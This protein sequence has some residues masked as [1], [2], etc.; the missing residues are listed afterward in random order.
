MILTTRR[1]ASYEEAGELAKLAAARAAKPVAFGAYNNLDG[2]ERQ[3]AQVGAM[4]DLHSKAVQASLARLKGGKLD[5]VWVKAQDGRDYLLEN[6]ADG[7]IV[8]RP[9]TIV[10]AFFHDGGRSAQS[11]VT[12]HPEATIRGK[13]RTMSYYIGVME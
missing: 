8:V 1:G 6:Q 7:R 12:G 13:G 4:V 3:L 5:H 9:S 10:N 11:Y 2:L